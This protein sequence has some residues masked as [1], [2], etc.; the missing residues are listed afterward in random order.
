MQGRRCDGPVMVPSQCSCAGMLHKCW[1]RHAMPD[2]K[3]SSERTYGGSM[4]DCMLPGHDVSHFLKR[5]GSCWS[6]SAPCHMWLSAIR[7]TGCPQ[8]CSLI[9]GR[10]QAFRRCCST[11]VVAHAAIVAPPCDRSKSSAAACDAVSRAAAAFQ[12]AAPQRLLAAAATPAAAVAYSCQL[13]PAAPA[14]VPAAAADVGACR[15]PAV[16][17]APAGAPAAATVGAPAEWAGV[18]DLR[19]RFLRSVKALVFCRAFAD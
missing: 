8:L 1:P 14:A 4:L 3:Q 2:H 12:R 13:R 17:G 5:G 16:P 11:P 18:R 19:L 10:T 6:L 9:I 15:V 7:L